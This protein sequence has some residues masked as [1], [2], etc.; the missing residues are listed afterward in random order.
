MHQSAPTSDVPSMCYCMLLVE[1]LT[2]GTWMNS[3]TLLIYGNAKGIVELVVFSEIRCGTDSFFSICI[4]INS[5][6]Y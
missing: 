5:S 3:K 4:H 6:M 2:A 1:H